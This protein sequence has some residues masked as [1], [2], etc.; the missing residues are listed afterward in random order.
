MGRAA[1]ME[2]LT[3]RQRVQAKEQLGL[4]RGKDP[5]YVTYS[6]N[7]TFHPIQYELAGQGSLRP[8]VF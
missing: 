6:I 5:L 1:Q 7:L 3:N 4:E 8:I 2:R